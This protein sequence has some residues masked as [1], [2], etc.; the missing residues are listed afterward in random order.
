MATALITGATSGIGLEIAQI[1]AKKYD[2]FLVS[3]DK[4]KLELLK[5][6]LEAE[7]NH[8]VH[9]MSIDLSKKNAAQKVFARAKRLSIDVLINNAGFGVSG[10]SVDADSSK[11]SAMLHLN[12]LTLTELSALFGQ[13][14]KA[15]KAGY[16]LNVA[17]IAAFQPVPYLASY[18]AS[19]SYVLNYTEALAK[20][21][22]EYSVHVTCLCPGV[23]ST[24]FYT[25]MGSKTKG[26]SPREVAIA[27]ITALFNQK[28]TVVP[29]F[30]NK[31]R[32]YIERLLPR[33]IIAMLSKKVMRKGMK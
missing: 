31:L 22:E 30:K 14:M 13:Q 1:L 28:M 4:K 18:S 6:S 20:E 29:G 19:K 21:L 15:E 17:S 24:N 9:V 25:A 2:L 16:I 8:T 12:I 33:A 10:E 11:V 5:K 23:T 26:G 27:G 32:I 3:R 7:H